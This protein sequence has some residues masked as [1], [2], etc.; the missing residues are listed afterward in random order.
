MRLLW[1][2]GLP[3]QNR[4]QSAQLLPVKTIPVLF[5]TTIKNQQKR[6]V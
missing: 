2:D 6:I 1:F 3:L 5:A 4:L